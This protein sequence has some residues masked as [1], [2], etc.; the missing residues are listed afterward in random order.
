MKSTILAVDDDQRLRE[1]LTQYLEDEGFTVDAAGNTAEARDMIG[2]KNYDGVILDVM[3]P[4]EDGFSFLSWMRKN[5]YLTP[6]MMLTAMGEVENRIEGLKLGAQDY[7]PKPFE[8]REL[9]LRLHNMTTHLQHIEQPAISHENPV[10][11]YVNFGEY[12]FHLHD[13]ALHKAG[14]RVK[15]SAAQTDLL[16]LLAENAPRPVSREEIS[17]Q[18]NGISLRSVDVH[19]ARL[20]RK[21]ET[22][23]KDPL[24]LATIRNQGYRLIVDIEDG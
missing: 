24:F 18:L 1:L 11:E 14:K 22:D 19:L 16:R 12:I 23:P 8:P 17:Q 2:Q 10:K 15:I 4:G 3:M 9:V 21:I 20:R 7:L 6:V 5:G 13:G